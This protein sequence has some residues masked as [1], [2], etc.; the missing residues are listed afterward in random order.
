MALLETSPELEWQ[1]VA[2]GLLFVA[3]NAAL[4]HFLDLGVGQ[5]LVTA[6]AR[7]IVQLTLVSHLLERAFRSRDPITT[8]GI[9]GV[10]L[11]AH[12]QRG[13]R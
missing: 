3:F 2:I 4:S 13:L 8:A 11:S 5:C 9:V 6:S 1:N 10:Y 7:C 12:T